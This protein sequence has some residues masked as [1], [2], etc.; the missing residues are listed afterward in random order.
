MYTFTTLHMLFHYFRRQEIVIG[1]INC[2]NAIGQSF[3]PILSECTLNMK[4]LLTIYMR[5]T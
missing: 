3:G 1:T 5:V 4:M 2:V